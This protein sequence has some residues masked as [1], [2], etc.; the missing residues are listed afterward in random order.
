MKKSK[1]QHNILVDFSSF[2]PHFSIPVFV[3]DE[4]GTI[5]ASNPLWLD[6]IGN[7]QETLSSLS[8]IEILGSNF[9]QTISLMLGDIFSGKTVKDTIVQLI[10][11]NKKQPFFFKVSASL[12]QQQYVI[13]T[14]VDVSEEVK[15]K[16]FLL[17]KKRQFFSI[18]TSLGDIVLKLD[19]TGNYKNFWAKDI[20]KFFPR[21]DVMEGKNLKDHFP[22]KV[23]DLFLLTIERSASKGQPMVMEFSDGLKEDEKWFS[24]KIAPIYAEGSTEVEEF[25]A[26]IKENTEERINRKQNKYKSGLIN[27][28]ANIKKGPILHIIKGKEPIFEFISGNLFSLT[29]YADTELNEMNWMDIILEN[30]RS[31]VQKCVDELKNQGGQKDLVYRIVTKEGEIN[32]I[33]NHITKAEDDG[34]AILFG[35]MLNVT[36][37]HLLNRDL[38][39]RDRILT[40]SGNIA[41]IGGWEYDVKNEKFHVTDEIYSIHEREEMDFDV[42]QSIDYYI[43]E[44]R[45]IIKQCLNN[46]LKSGQNYD[47]ELQLKT[48][49]GN[50]KWVR[51]V[52]FAEWH[53]GQLTHIFGILQDINEKKEKDLILQENEKRFNT[54]FELAPIGIGLLA[55]NG[56]WIKVNLALSQFFELTEEQLKKNSFGELNLTD[57]WDKK[58]EWSTLINIKHRYKH[59]LEKKYFTAN[60]GVKWGRVSINP[61]KNDKGEPLYY[62][63]QMVDITESKQFEENLIIAKKEAEDANKA[64]SDFLSTMSHEIRT[65]LYGVIGITNLLLEEIGDVK[66]REQLKA[67]K[68]S[69]DS[70]LLLVNDILDFS[71]IRSGVLSLESKPFELKRL[72][73]A[74][75]ETHS[76]KAK[77][78]GN[79]ILLEYDKDI[80]DQIVGDELRTGQILNNLVNNAVK[81]TE[82]GTIKLTI[83]KLESCGNTHR[84]FFS[85]KDTGIGIPEEMHSLVFEQFIQAESGTS[86]KYGGTGLG[87]SIVKGL[88]TAMD[89]QI[90][91]TSELGK[92]TE[93][94]FEL[95]L[96]EATTN[97]AVNPNRDEGHIKNLENKTILLVEDNP[98][99]MMVAGDYINKWKGKVIKAIN[100]YE[101][102]ENFRL[103]MDEIDLIL[104][105][106]QM[107]VLN[108][109]EAAEQIKKMRPDVPIIALTASL[110]NSTTQ[111]F[112]NSGMVAHVIK[113]F[114]PNEFYQII[115][116][117]L[118]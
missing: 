43:E 32:W 11:T 79:K 90:K 39:Q 89:S 78:L 54:A 68:F 44:H 94:S 100:G 42:V 92:G 2:L 51:S 9:S 59:Q 56:R 82:A 108:G 107:P 114:N 12:F 113:P 112:S 66:H 65:P 14:A 110:G 7:Q 17:E 16:D 111:K 50:I 48:G 53:N 3:V 72:A 96:Q 6:V 23:V 93:I 52:G 8:K 46:L 85:V 25:T 5:L 29:G 30:D 15:L 77:K 95:L 97:P 10:H 63:F 73:E 33:S 38:K 58:C 101:A 34:Q 62:I 71:K 41:M 83:K 80:P 109:F 116:A 99:S 24:V 88:L 36:E 40:Q 105:D 57:T 55:P 67:L 115:K 86:R 81:F 103:N 64:K 70:L 75:K 49:K 31:Y 45:P 18:V 91:L 84:L 19:R 26:I 117:H 28:L 1:L 102:V 104:M 74:V 118:R 4:Q 76:Q 69:S 13:F 20:S 21:M 22:K 106:L 27:Q 47:V 61:V 60:G 35:V 37:V 87:L 98:V